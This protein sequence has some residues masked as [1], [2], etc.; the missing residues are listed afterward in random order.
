METKHVAL[1]GNPNTGKS[2]VFNQLTGLKQHVGNYP[3][4]T[5]DKKYG[6][7][8][9]DNYE[10]KLVDLPG[11]YSLY[12]QSEEEKVVL[13]FLEDKENPEFPEVFVCICDSTNLERNL[14][15][16]TQLYDKNIPLLLVL[17]MKD[18]AEQE[19]LKINLEVLSSKFA[20]VKIIESNARKGEGI[21]E[22]EKAIDQFSGFE[23]SEEFVSDFGIDHT[24]ANEQLKST[25]IRFKKIKAL[26]NEVLS[27][28]DST[29]E[30]V[31]NKLDSILLNKF[32]SFPILL[33][34][35]FIVFQAVFYVS[36]T[37][38]DWIDGA[39]GS[40]Q[41]WL[42]NTLPDGPFFDLITEGLIPG[43]GGVVI[44]IPQI[45]LL[46][47]ILAIL[48]ETGYMTRVV[49]LL[50]RLMRPFGLNGRSI[51]PLVSGFACAIPG[52]MATRTIENW[53]ERM[54]TI[55]V[56]PFMSCSARLPV[57]TI[58]IAIIIPDESIG[59][60]FNLKGLVLF[61][62]Y[63]LGVVIA[64][65]SAL[66]FKFILKSKSKSYLILEM[67]KYKVPQVKNV[68]LLVLEK[69]KVFVLN[70]GKIIVAVS[71][72]LWVLAS[73]GPSK[74]EN[75][76][77]EIS[78]E[79][80]YI[81]IA[82]KAIEPAIAPLGYDWKMGIAIITSFAAREVFVGTMATIY[83]VSEEENEGLTLQDKMINDVDK[84]SGKPLFNLASGVSLLLFYAF[85]MQC[86]STFAVVYRETKSYKWPIIQF[87]YMSAVAYFS[88]LLA[89]QILS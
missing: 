81:G 27:K 57:Y 62:L 52:I 20:N 67:P 55:M 46:F 43:I 21:K 56:T 78:I 66:L 25:N 23:K 41:E 37:P 76:Q 38:M 30:I 48:E 10:V 3:G 74:H 77:G 40:L 60:I 80:S 61:A 59:G 6:N 75:E 1:I 5:V 44:F 45:A 72:V 22:I 50:D 82:G 89:Y 34:I 16:F 47:G 51:V 73:N 49:F 32:L 24:K 79:N 36:E 69:C 39:F 54:I 12:G 35:L 19:G 11:I 26:L 58:L 85:A 31:T 7:F 84:V 83:G 64:L 70:A 86:A 17:N 87:V 8:D 28:P 68:L 65:L 13:N 88:A 2:S 29:E 4:V 63:L 9:T 33:G 15:L 14:L 42:T 71:I 18:E 53:K